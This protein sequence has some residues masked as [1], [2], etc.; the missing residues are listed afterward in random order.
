MVDAQVRSYV[1][2]WINSNRNKWRNKK[3]KK[4]LEN[5]KFD[6][7]Y[8]HPSF[9]YGVNLKIGK[10]CH[11]YPKVQVG[12]NCNIRS[13]VELRNGT[14]IGDDCYIDSGVRSS[15]ECIIGSRVTLRYNAIIA[16]GTKIID[17]VF[18]SPQLMTE[19]LNHKGESIGGAQIGV[20]LWTRRTPFRV[21]IGTN[22]TLAAGISICPGVIIGSKANVRKSITKPGVY[23]GNPARKI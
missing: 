3:M 17:D 2:A 8:I 1:L 13:Y 14:I 6:G 19:N 10:Y 4:N 16:K 9:K 11:I 5:S 23:L 21:F 22:V 12:D 20:G 18:I 15:G 7:N